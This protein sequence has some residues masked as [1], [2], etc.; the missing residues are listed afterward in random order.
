MFIRNTEII[1]KILLSL[2]LACSS[3][4]SFSQT[5]VTFYTTQGDF[6]VEI[7]DNIVPITGG[8]FLDLMDSNFYDGV[9]FHRVISGFMIQGGD[10]TGTGSGGPGY[11][12]RDEL[13]AAKEFGYGPGILAMAN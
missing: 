7:Y 12:F 11:R 8:N 3:I 4:I 2:F 10:P 13:D 1:K 9:I 6:V 5:T